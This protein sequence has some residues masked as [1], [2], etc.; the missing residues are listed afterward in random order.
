MRPAVLLSIALLTL[1]GCR[2][3]DPSPPQRKIHAKVAAPVPAIEPPQRP[4]A[5]LSDLSIT[6]QV[7]GQL[8]AHCPGPARIT[9]TN[10]STE[11]LNLILPTERAGLAGLFHVSLRDENGRTY[12]GWPGPLLAVGY[13]MPSMRVPLLPG[14]SWSYSIPD[15][16][17]PEEPPPY[18]NIPRRFEVYSGP[19]KGPRLR[20]PAGRY[21]VTAEYVCLPNHILGPAREPHSVDWFGEIRSDP[22]SITVKK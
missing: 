20:L 16:T 13:L 3:D 4:H 22:V 14:S 10:Q 21:A 19:F 9:L 18:L 17:G 8:H 11:R 15:L 5:S 7:S 2:P 12:Q 6:L 1:V